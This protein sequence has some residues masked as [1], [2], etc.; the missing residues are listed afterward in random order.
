MLIFLIFI[1]VIITVTVVL[2]N[3]LVKS[4]NRMKEGWSGID[5]Q[6]KRRHSLVPS[7]VEIVK[8][9]TQHEAQLLE[10]L[11]RLRT[12]SEQADSP[13]DIG[14]K[15]DALSKGI[16]GVIL[17]AEAYPDLKATKN[18]SATQRTAGRDRRLLAESSALLQTARCVNITLR[19]KAS[20]PSSS[21]TPST[22]LPP[23]ILK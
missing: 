9:Y 17:L 23:T 15:E 2:Y 20:P 18:F 13:N 12:A 8:G 21:Q 14:K 5:V 16:K 1:T 10:D 6:L 4:R 19:S 11:T 22:F 7:L 3:R